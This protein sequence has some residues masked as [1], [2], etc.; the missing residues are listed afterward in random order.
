MDN[1]AI[2]GLLAS[3][4][5]NVMH[6]QAVVARLEADNE[7]LRKE[8]ADHGRGAGDFRPESVKAPDFVDLPTE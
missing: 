8:L 1:E 2:L 4:Y 3:L 6:L 7:A 5:N